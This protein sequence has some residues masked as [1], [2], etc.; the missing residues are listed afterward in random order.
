MSLTTD[1]HLDAILAK[2]RAGIELAKH[3]GVEMEKWDWDGFHKSDAAFILACDNSAEAGW[4]STIAAIEGLR[5]MP[6]LDIRQRAFTAI[7]A[8]WPIELL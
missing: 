7:I 2:C 4:R 5:A 6:P 8:A 3:R 1:Q